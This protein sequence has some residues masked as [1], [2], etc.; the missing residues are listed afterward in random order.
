MRAR[1]VLYMVGSALGFSAMA[2]L[3]KLGSRDLPTGE[4]VLA[5]AVVTLVLSYVMVRR[6]GRPIWGTARRKL[7]LRGL[8]GFGGLACYYLA[9]VRLP[10]AEATTIYNVTPLLTALLAWR[11]LGERVGRAGALA[12]A[13]GLVGVVLVLRP[14]AGG[15][16]LDPLGIAVALTA[17]VTSAFAYVTVRQLA[18]TEHPLTIVFYFPLVAT[19]L[20]IPW[21]LAGA[22]WPAPGDWLILLG[23]GVATQIG[24]VFLTLALVTERAGRAT[25]AGYLQVCFAMLWGYGLFGETPAWTT[26]VGAALV[27]GGTLLVAATAPAPGRAPEERAGA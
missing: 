6:S 13:V 21:A 25:T 17:A 5:R 16:S 19:P 4:L 2:V 1:G 10:L 11:V 20:A 8:L 3:V 22:T 27:I 12:L 24:Q 15:V 7:A 23:I 18:R 26:A 9:V 14:H